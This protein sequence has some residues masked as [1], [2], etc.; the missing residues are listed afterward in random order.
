MEKGKIIIN[1]TREMP[2][3]L[4]LSSPLIFR[5]FTVYFQLNLIPHPDS[6]DLFCVL[7][8]YK[9]KAEYCIWD[10]FQILSLLNYKYILP[11]LFCSLISLKI[12]TVLLQ[13]GRHLSQS[14]RSQIRCIQLKSHQTFQP[15]DLKR[16]LNSQKKSPSSNCCS[17]LCL[18]FSTNPRLLI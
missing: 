14:F 9:F 11:I 8:A 1:I 5:L 3:H 7:L 18:N 2:F 6:V 10:I 16:P 13:L 4:C 12:I 17:K 15:P